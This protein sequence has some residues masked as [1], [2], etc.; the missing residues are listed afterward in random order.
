MLP[1]V[2]PAAVMAMNFRFLN[3]CEVH[4]SAFHLFKRNAGVSASALIGLNARLRTV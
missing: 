4:Q 3:F 1:L 2:Q